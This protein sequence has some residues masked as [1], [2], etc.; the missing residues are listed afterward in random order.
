MKK[1]II[2]LCLLLLLAGCGSGGKTTYWDVI[3]DPD[4]SISEEGEPE[5]EQ[6]PEFDYLD[7][8]AAGI[9]KREMQESYVTGDDIDA[10][11]ALSNAVLESTYVTVLEDKGDSCTL[12]IVYPDAASALMEK[13]ESL[14]EDADT[15]KLDRALLDVAKDI[16]K[17][18]V[19][20]LEGTFTLPIVKNSLGVAYIQWSAE[21]LDAMSGGMAKY[22]V[23]G[24]EVE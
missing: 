7:T 4:T 10:G 18:K 22:L 17:G 12:R 8:S 2:A 14:P 1:S 9:V 3:L 11:A 21:A 16:E 19:A 23:G 13:A 15:E 20:T 6:L 5:E 24:A